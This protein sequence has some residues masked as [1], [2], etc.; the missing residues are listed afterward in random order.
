[1]GEMARTLVFTGEKQIEIQEY[2][3]PE[4][5]DDMV[6]V[7]TDACAICTWEQRVYTG[8]KKVDFPF[9]GG[10]EMVGKIVKMGKNVDQR[11]WNVGDFVAVG[12]TLPCK[13][14]YQCKSG[15]EQNCENFDHSKQLEGLPEKGMGGLSSHLLVHPSNLFHL[16]DITPEEATITE[17]LSCV[18]HS[19]ETAD[20]Q[21]GDTVV[22][23]GCGIMGL[24]HTILATKRGASVIVSDT[25][26]ERTKLGLELG[27]KYAVNPAE[28]DLSERVKEIT[29][30]IMAQ[31]VFDT[32]PISKVAED[33]VKAVANNGRLVLYSS[34]YPDTPISISPDWLHKSGAKLMG[35]ANSNTV[36]FTKA[37]RLLSEGVVDVKPFVSEVYDLSDYQKAFES[38][39]KGDKFRVVIKF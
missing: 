28:E 30:G 20:I 16:H 3:I 37:T 9:I 7:K 22:V 10:H 31:V 12:V 36:D 35:T 38:A 2:P 17:P 33:A 8:V 39:I 15:N 24:L 34:F 25:N 11:Q 1:M 18:L 19:V 29:G 5:S 13:N 4:V 14:C 32:T 6:L 23:I 27:A 21:F 26:E